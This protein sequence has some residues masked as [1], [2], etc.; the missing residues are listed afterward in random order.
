MSNQQ[1]TKHYTLKFQKGTELKALEVDDNMDDDF[2][3]TVLSCLTSMYKRG[4]CLINITQE[5]AT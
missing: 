1:L 4:F 5:E 2:L 3:D